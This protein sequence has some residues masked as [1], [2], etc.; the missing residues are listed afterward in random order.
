M[1]DNLKKLHDAATPGPWRADVTPPGP[2]GQVC[3]SERVVVDHRIA[4]HFVASRGMQ[5]MGRWC[6]DANLIAT[7]RNATPAI[8]ALVEAVR[9]VTESPSLTAKN[10]LALVEALAA[11]DTAVGNEGA[12]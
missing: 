5:G 12:E 4:S 8:L 3:R 2:G 9:D 6:A 10:Y 11:Y 7:L 1:T